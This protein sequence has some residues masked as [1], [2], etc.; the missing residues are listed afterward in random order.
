MRDAVDELVS[1]GHVHLVW[2]LEGVSFMDSTGLGVLVYTMRSVEAREGSVRLAGPD[3]QVRRL[4]ELTGLDAVVECHPYVALARRPRP[5]VAH[6]TRGTLTRLRAVGSRGHCGA[7]GSDHP[8]TG[9][10][11]AGAFIHANSG[12]AKT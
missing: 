2:D 12:G 8:R 4:L 5:L 7:V 10:V 9:W 3:G 6:P 1:E 11:A